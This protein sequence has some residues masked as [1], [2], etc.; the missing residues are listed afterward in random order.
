MIGSISLFIC[1]VGLAGSVC[2][3]YDQYIENQQ[4][5]KELDELK[6]KYYFDY[7]KKQQKENDING[8]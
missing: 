3:A 1:G 8:D 7:L 6:R 2:L 4:I 5:K